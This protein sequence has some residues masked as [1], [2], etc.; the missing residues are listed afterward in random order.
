[1]P[2]RSTLPNP[3]KLILAFAGLSLGALGVVAV[4]TLVGAGLAGPTIRGGERAVVVLLAFDLAVAAS[5]VALFAWLSGSWSA[6][7]ARGLWI[8]AFSVA[9][10]LGLAMAAFLTLVILNR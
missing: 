4:A 2:R 5:C 6:G 7:L 3:L 10:I 9:Q 1:M 8:A